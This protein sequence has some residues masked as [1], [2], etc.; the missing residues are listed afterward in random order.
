MKQNPT[1]YRPLGF[2]KHHLEH[3]LIL[4]PEGLQGGVEMRAAASW[5]AGPAPSGLPG[6]LWDSEQGVSSGLRFLA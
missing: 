6:L 3:S 5:E 2:Q 1:L 4:A